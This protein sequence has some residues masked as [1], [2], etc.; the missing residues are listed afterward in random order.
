MLEAFVAAT[1]IMA[2][3]E[4]RRTDGVIFDTNNLKFNSNT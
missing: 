2:G 1:K 4:R 3:D